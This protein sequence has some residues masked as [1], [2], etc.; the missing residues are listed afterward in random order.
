MNLT[1]LSNAQ[2]QT[3]GKTYFDLFLL[4]LF[5]S[6][7]GH[8]I[9][10]ILPVHIPLVWNYQGV[11]CCVAWEL[12]SACKIT[13]TFLVTKE[14]KSVGSV[15]WVLENIKV[16]LTGLRVK[17][18]E[19]TQYLNSLSSMKFVWCCTLFLIHKRLTHPCTEAK[20][21]AVLQCCHISVLGNGF[22][23]NDWLAK[24]AGW[25]SNAFWLEWWVILS[26]SSVWVDPLTGMDAAWY[27]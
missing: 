25:E 11:A 22:G 20:A 18:A 12:K 5:S 7:S 4:C 2:F 1:A 27:D 6:Y 13:F 16:P 24:W 10:W 19:S 3:S 14:R 26:V 8:F 23:W 15:H 9:H 17:F 21:M